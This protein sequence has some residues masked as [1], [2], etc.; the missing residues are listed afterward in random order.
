M[1]WIPLTYEYVTCFVGLILLHSITRNLKL[2]L[3]CLLHCYFPFA[4]FLLSLE[5]S[6]FSRSIIDVSAVRGCCAAQVGSW[7]PMIGT[8]SVP[9][10]RLT[11]E[12]GTDILSRNVSYQ[13]PTYA[14]ER[15]RKAMTTSFLSIKPTWCTVYFSM[16]I[17]FLAMFRAIVC[18]SSGETTVFVR[19]LVHVIL[20]GWLSGMQGGIPHVEKRNKHAMKSCA[21]SWLYLLDYR[22]MHGQRNIKATSFLFSRKK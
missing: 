21:P 12:D 13:I 9:S 17:S 2:N 8:T 10:W 19:H 20:F 3:S 14:E 4:L 16:F 7:L 11:L 15:S 18:P 5:V 6:G 1:L 22:G